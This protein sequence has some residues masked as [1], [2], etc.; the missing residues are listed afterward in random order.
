VTEIGRNPLEQLVEFVERVAAGRIVQRAE[1]GRQGIR[2][3]S[4]RIRHGK[5]GGIEKNVV[6]DIVELVKNSP[7][8]PVTVH[9]FSKIELRSLINI[10]C[11]SPCSPFVALFIFACSMERSDRGGWNA[12]G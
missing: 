3:N 4:R 12:C 10:S 8:A 9:R 1:I 2:I 11:S 6:A 5:T 7:L